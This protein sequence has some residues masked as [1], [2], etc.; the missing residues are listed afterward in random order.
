VARKGQVAFVVP[1]PTGGVPGFSQENL[2]GVLLDH[3]ETANTYEGPFAHM[4]GEVRATPRT[5]ASSRS[6]SWRS[7]RRQE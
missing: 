6:Q 7:H 1:I 5:P 3:P 4:D 2:D